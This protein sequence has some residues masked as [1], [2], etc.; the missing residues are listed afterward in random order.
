ME[1]KQGDRYDK[2]Y[3]AGYWDG[4]ND[5]LNHRDAILVADDLMVL[6]I[7]VMDV[8]TR[9]RNCLSQAGCRS[10]GDVASLGEKSIMTMRN[11]GVKTASEIAQWLTKHGICHSAWTKYL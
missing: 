1:E 11:L 7:K 4:V 10:V 5:A 8:S 6:P 9:A 2:G 3:M